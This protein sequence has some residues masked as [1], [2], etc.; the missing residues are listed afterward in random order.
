MISIGTRK[1]PYKKTGYGITPVLL[2]PGGPGFTR[3]Y[4]SIVHQS[5]PES[6]FTVVSYNPSGTAETESAPFY[7]SVAEFATEVKGVLDQLNLNDAFLLGHS[8]GTAVVQEMLI[9]HPALRVKGII[10]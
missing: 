10:L 1:L 4:F 8:W 2:V 5:L 9:Q 7:A 3:D 6:E